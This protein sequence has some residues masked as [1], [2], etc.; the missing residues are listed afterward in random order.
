MRYLAR[1]YE[2]G[3]FNPFITEPNVLEV[4]EEKEPLYPLNIEFPIYVKK[5]NENIW[6]KGEDE[7]LE[8]PKK[9]QRRIFQKNTSAE[10]DT[11]KFTFS[12]QKFQL[13]L[14][15]TKINVEPSN[16]SKKISTDS[17]GDYKAVFSPQARR[18]RNNKLNLRRKLSLSPR[19]MDRIKIKQTSSKSKN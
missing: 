8:S 9:I 3:Y 10:V 12:Q 6:E 15:P 1:F 16:K 2:D 18:D 11:K 4:E 5:R 7:D 17:K 14:K 19:R 13:N